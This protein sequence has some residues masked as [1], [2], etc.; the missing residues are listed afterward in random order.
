MNP[1]RD[2]LAAAPLA[3]CLAS[4]QAEEQTFHFNIPVQPLP[5]ALDALAAQTGIKP[6]YSDQVVS[7]KTGHAVSGNLTAAQA[8][9][10]LLSGTGL[11]FKFNGD[12]AVAIT[13]PDANSA[14]TLAA[15]TVVAK[16]NAEQFDPNN[17]NY[18]RAFASASTKTDTPLM[19][20][21]MTVQVVPRQVLS[22]QQAIRLEDAV[23]N[24]SGVQPV[25]TSGGQGQDFVIRGFGTNYSRFRNGQRISNFNA[26]LANIEQVEVLKGPAA[27]LFGRV[28]PGGMV[29][30][31]TKKPLSE[32]HYSLQQQFGSYDLYRTVAEATG[33]LNDDKSLAYRLDFG[34][35]DRNSFR[36]F[37]SQTQVFVAPSLHWQASDATEFN[38]SLEYMDRNLP[39]DTGIPAVGTRVAN[40]PINTNYGQPGGQFNQDPSDSTLLDFNWSHAFNDHWTFKNGFVANW[41]TQHYRELLVAV[42]QPLL[43]TDNNPQVVRRGSQFE[44]RT[45]ESYNAFFN[46]NGK[47]ATGPVNHNVLVG[48]DYFY[49]E[50]RQSG[51]FGFNAVNAPANSPYHFPADFGGGN[52]AFTRVN[53]YNPVYANLDYNAYEFQ[54]INHPNDFSINQTSW[55]GLYFQD[56]LAFFDGKLQ[57]LGGGRYDW[58]HQATGASTSYQNSADQND[59]YNGYIPSFGNVN[60]AAQSEG[61]FSPRVGILYRPWNWL[62]LYGNRVEGFGTNNGRSESGQPLKPETA[63][64]YEAGLKGEWFKGDLTANLA[65]FHIDKQNVATLVREGISETIGA[66]RSQGIE[67]DVAGQ[68]GGGFSLIASYA[69]TDARITQDGALSGN[70]GHRLPNV[71]EHSGS[72]WLKY[73]FQHQA[74]S[75]LQLGIG[76]YLAGKREGDNA[77]SYQ[78]PGYVR[79]DTSVGYSL[80]L[81]ASKLTTQLNVYNIFDKRYFVAGEPYNANRAWNMPGDPLTVIGSMKL[82]F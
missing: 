72:T 51:F 53:L 60:L 7:G 63:E 11:S 74:L 28:Q 64:Q 73:A 17:A 52:F 25:W 55:Y 37:V 16:A 79:V 24:V 71:A 2:L 35:T 31:V 41:T 42:F 39:Y 50:V 76:A 57:I 20:T 3:V 27:M 12:H 18:N 26:D 66:A 59:N 54:R 8:L 6:F 78:L 77:N 32:A 19:D 29:N 80:H 10:Q 56:H 49:D 82:E 65:Y 21:P 81:G 67:M 40:V 9:Q 48:G 68:L 43:A 23:K 38:L 4:A 13:Q 30:V 36:D 1:L 14:A 58:A 22:D 44:D 45:E 70:I 5:A 33:P 75:G 46:L 69:F 34:Y 62:S 47:F 15:V 61:F